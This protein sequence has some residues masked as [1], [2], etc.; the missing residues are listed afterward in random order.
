MTNV[1][2]RKNRGIATPARVLE[3]LRGA[4]SWLEAAEDSARGSGVG[5]RI[6]VYFADGRIDWMYPHGNTGEVISAW[7]DLAVLLDRPAYIQRAIRYARTLLDDPV[8]G[9]YRGP[10][11]EAHGMAWYWTD[12]G[13][14]SGLYSMRLPWHFDRL[15]SLTGDEEFREICEVIGR[16]LLSRQRSSGLVDAGWSPERGWDEGGTRVGCRF[17]YSIGTFATLYRLTG[18][19][20][21]LRGY[22]RSVRALIKMQRPDGSFYQHYLAESAEPHPTERSVKPF[23]YG[24]ILNAIAEA[25][26]VFRDDR[27]LKVACRLGD[28]L[29]GTYAYRNSIPYCTGEM[30]PADRTEADA[31]VTDSANGLFWLSKETGHTA[32]EDLALKLWIDAWKSQLEA[33]GRAGWDGAI[34]QGANPGLT[35]TLAGVPANRTHLRFD[36]LK[37]GKCS[38]W[39]MVN[40]ISASRRIREMQSHEH[41][42]IDSELL[43]LEP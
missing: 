41:D 25:H 34:I 13:S 28:C 9:I 33:P 11:A 14:Y 42:S 1:S 39:A 40:H 31:F 4:A 10:L 3:S 18:S 35:E 16:T 6:A 22:E 15:A 20:G 36:P 37:L 12:G 30:P 27:L 23:F 29:I 5:H 17:I 19:V 21:Y 2:L 32:Y 8:R 26:S 7:L 24:Y 38:L 43:Q